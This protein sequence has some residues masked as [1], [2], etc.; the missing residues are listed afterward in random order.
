[1]NTQQTPF[2]GVVKEDT[3]MDNKDYVNAIYRAACFKGIC[4][5]VTE[6]AE[7]LETNRS[8]VSSA[9]NGSEKYLTKSFIRKVKAFALE[10]GLEENQAKVV[11][12]QEVEDEGEG[13]DEKDLPHIWDRYQKSSHGFSRSMTSTGLGLAIVKGIADAHHAAYGVESEKGKGSVFW[14]ELRETHEA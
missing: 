1:M 14:L 8:G 7:K 5:S 2:V 3:I 12:V 11:P 4:S 10:Y 13:I 9:L 6:F